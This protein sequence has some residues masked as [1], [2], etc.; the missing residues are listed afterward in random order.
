MSIT[1]EPKIIQDVGE[2]PLVLYSDVRA[3]LASLS[4][5]RRSLAMAELSMIAYN[6]EAEAQRAARAIGFPEAHCSTTMDRRRFDFA[7]SLTSFWPAGGRRSPSGTTSRPMP[8][9]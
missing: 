8:T 5:L 7:M 2:E 3:P 6:D 4:F 1:L 9:P